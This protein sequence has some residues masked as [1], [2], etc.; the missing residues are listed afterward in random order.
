MCEIVNMSPQSHS[1][2]QSY[3][4]E[5]KEATPPEARHFL[6]DTSAE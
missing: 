3:F 5:L 1:F 6:A 2:S 4:T